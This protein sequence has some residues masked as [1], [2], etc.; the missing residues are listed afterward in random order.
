MSDDRKAIS[1]GRVLAASAWAL[2]S[3]GSVRMLGLVSTIVLARLLTPTDFGIV[4][5]AMIVVGFSE[6]VLEFGVR[7]ILIHRSNLTREDYDTAWTLNVIQ[8]AMATAITAALA[9]PAAHYFHDPRL[10]VVILALATG[11]MI[12]SMENIGVVNFQ[13]DLEF[14]RDFIL[15]VARKMAGVVVGITAAIIFQSYWAMVCGYLATQTVGTTVS[16]AIHPYR[17]RLSFAKLRE[18]LRFSVWLSVRQV[19]AFAR[20]RV[21]RF[22]VGGSASSAVMG[23]YTIASEL[24]EIVSSELMAPI[25]RALLPAFA[26]LQ[27]QHE[28]LRAAV[29]TAIGGV[30]TIVMPAAAGMAFVAH[31]LVVVVLGSKWLAAVPI[32]QI[33]A[34]A[35]LLRS[36]SFTMGMLLTAVGRLAFHTF[37]IW[38]QVAA[39]WGLWAFWLYTHGAEGAALARLGAASGF[40][41][42]M[43]LYAIVT[44]FLRVRDLIGTLTRPVAATA[45][46]IAVLAWLQPQL[47]NGTIT[48]LAM[49]VVAG[50]STYSSLLIVLWAASGRPDGVERI[51]LNHAMERLHAIRGGT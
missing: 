12:G 5:M 35:V 22:I 1:S 44:G 36:V 14:S 13:R 27:G 24:T 17:P 48:A 8:G 46:M 32:L 43:C 19:G 28:R 3:R 31:D 10:P 50:V 37:M 40:A 34:L 20:E 23:Y 41:A 4:G 2:I 26:G 51:V 6:A 39:F 21:D 33:L 45:G 38:L 29:R 7:A 11:M 9:I 18:F 25:G 49:C 42:I 16:Y 15:F 47:A 30:T